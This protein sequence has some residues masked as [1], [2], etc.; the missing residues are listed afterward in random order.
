[1]IHSFLH[2]GL[3][4]ER[5]IFRSYLYRFMAHELRCHLQRNTH[6]AKFSAKCGAK[7]MKFFIWNTVSL[8]KPFEGPPYISLIEKRSVSTGE[9]IIGFVIIPFHVTLMPF[10][11]KLQLLQD[12]FMQGKVSFRIVFRWAYRTSVKL[13]L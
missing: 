8:V 11:M 6:F 10:F 12:Y 3:R 2:L 1:M 7:R 4:Y 13:P 5:V 9:N